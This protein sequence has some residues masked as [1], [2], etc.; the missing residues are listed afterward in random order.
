MS[1]QLQLKFD[2]NQDYQLDAV[3]SVVS[4]FDGLSQ[5]APEFGLGGDIISNL[6]PQENL[7]E[8][9]LRDNLRAVQEKNKID[10]RLADLEMDDGM[11]LNGVCDHS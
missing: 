1:K 5:R 8:S 6:P 9:W 10:N 4:L 11:E 2:G 3:A 7:N